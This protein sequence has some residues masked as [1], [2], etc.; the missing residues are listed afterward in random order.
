M[1][2]LIEYWPGWEGML[3]I[4]RGN[5]PW[6]EECRVPYDGVLLSVLSTGSDP[7]RACWP[8]SRMRHDA[9]LYIEMTPD[10]CRTRQESYSTFFG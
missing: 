2:V 3:P 7:Q 5:A 10:A 6:L 9:P 1:N 4:E 8:C